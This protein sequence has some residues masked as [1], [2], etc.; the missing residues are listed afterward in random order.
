MFDGPGKEDAA[1]TRG[2]PAVFVGGDGW[3]L[4]AEGVVGLV[5]C[6]SGYD[7]FRWCGDGCSVEDCGATRTEGVSLD[8]GG[9][10]DAGTDG[11]RCWLD[12][13][14]GSPGGIDARGTGGTNEAVVSTVSMAGGSAWPVVVAWGGAITSGVWIAASADEDGTLGRLGALTSGTVFVRLVGRS[15]GS[16]HVSLSRLTSCR[17]PLLGDSCLPSMR[18]SERL[19]EVS[20]GSL[21]GPERC[22]HDSMGEPECNV[23][24]RTDDLQHARTVYDGIGRSEPKTMRRSGNSSTDKLFTE[25]GCVDTAVITVGLLRNILEVIGSEPSGRKRIGLL[26]TSGQ[27]MASAHPSIVPLAVVMKV[28]AASLVATNRMRV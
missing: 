20:V 13:G 3:P 15:S 17:P 9:L 27:C 26:P 18:W 21:S 4:G 12:E 7:T 6:A 10:E 1:G 28:S 5:A 14:S 19:V 22:Q 8:V 24:Q 25:C 23:R 11:R 2:W 16:A